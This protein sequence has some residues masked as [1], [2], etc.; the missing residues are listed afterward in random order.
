MDETVFLGQT[1]DC[2]LK[3]SHESDVKRCLLKP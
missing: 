1:I 3:D 2:G